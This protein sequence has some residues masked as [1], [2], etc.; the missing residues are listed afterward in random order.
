MKDETSEAGADGRWPQL[1]IQIVFFVIVVSGIVVLFSQYLRRTS[2]FFPDRHPSG[3]W[4]RSA[5][6]VTPSDHS[7]S[8]TDGVRLHAWLFRAADPHAPLMI[9]FHGNGGNLTYRAEM[10]A[11]FAS[12]G[13]S[14]FLFDWRGYGR[15]EGTPSEAKLFLDSRAAYDYAATLGAESIAVY[16]ESL[17][18][19]YAARVA[20]ERKVSSAIIEN[21]SPHSVPWAT[22]STP[23]F[24][25]GGPHRGRCARLT[26]STKR[27]CRS[28]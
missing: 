28:S 19:P 12:R 24:H 1:L 10:A 20:K 2:M 17:G 9:W 5:F 8:T 21:S 3:Y 18:G 27:T 26:G 7:F 4:D 15:S 23:H 13:V 11:R 14:V 16:G 22:R 6:E 25:S